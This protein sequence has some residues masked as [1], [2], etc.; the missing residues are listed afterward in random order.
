[1]RYGAIYVVENLATGRV[2]VGQTTTTIARR[3]CSHLSEARRGK[4]DFPL[5][6]A[7]RKHGPEQFSVSEFAEASCQVEL[8]ALEIETIRRLGS[9]VRDGGYNLSTGGKGGKLSPETRRK[10]GDARRG[11]KHFRFGKKQLPHVVEAMRAGRLGK[12]HSPEAIEKIRAFMTGRPVSQEAKERISAAN[13]GR[14]MPPHVLDALRQANLGKPSHRRVAVQN[15]E[16][17]EMFASLHEAAERAGVSVSTMHRW[18]KSG[19]SFKRAEPQ[20]HT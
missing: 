18:V 11:E 2:Y 5:Y 7:I 14:P 1:M 13:S 15:A 19:L 16:T 4:F 12:K 8:D 9:L 3:W 17:G 20:A 6:R 10:M